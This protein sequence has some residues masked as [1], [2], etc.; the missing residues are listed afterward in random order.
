MSILTNPIFYYIDPITN[1][2]F[3]LNFIEPDAANI[4]LTASLN[5]AS[6][7]MDQLDNEVAR[8]L[9]S[10]GIN[11]YTVTFNRTTRL[12]TIAADGNFNLLITSGSN[13]GTSVFPL[14]GYTGADVTGLASYDAGTIAGAAYEPQF[15]LQNFIGFDISKE[16]IQTKVNES[17]SGEVEVVT[18]GTKRIMKFNIKYITNNTGT[19]EAYASCTQAD[20]VQ[21]AIDF[22][23]F[24][25][26]KNKLEFMKDKSS[27][28][29][30]DNILLEST[31]SS[32]DGSGYELKE[33]YSQNLTGY[34]ETGRLR[35]RKL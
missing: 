12:Y 6:Y 8:A 20:H 3:Q 9:N 4:E 2:N 29:T 27:R 23:E 18:F 19:R 10:A 34:Y 5:V 22:M 16:G 15:P 14:I 31:A 11:E 25:T 17:S 7:T 1:D 30:F 32:R 13:N 33:L 21:E 35:F 28:S 26:G 24:I